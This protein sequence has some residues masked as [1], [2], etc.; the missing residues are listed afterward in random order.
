MS[1]TV[2]GEVDDGI[3]T[4]RFVMIQALLIDLD[5]VLRIWNPER[6][7]QAEQIAG[8]PAGALRQALFAPDILTPAITGQITD[9]AWRIAIADRL[10]TQFPNAD[11]DRAVTLW[12]E[13]SGEIDAAVLEVVRACRKN[14]PVALITNATS[15]LPYDLQRLSVV[16]EFDHIINSSIVGAIKPEP[17]IFT[18]AL[19]AVN[20]A[21]A[22]A[23]FVDDSPG[24]VEAAL[25]MGI[26]GHV[27]RG[28]DEFARLVQEYGLV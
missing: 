21:P 19:Q 12:S 8:L 15:R 3:D 10:H 13:S 7:R 23:L 4:G 22:T 26:V 2:G 18:A 24:H 17:A 9:E 1:I 16:G 20:V 5:G 28:V 14:V 6:D 27:Y 25:Q 11:A